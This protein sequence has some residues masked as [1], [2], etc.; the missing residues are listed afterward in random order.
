MN[1]TIKTNVF[2]SS[3]RLPVDI[4]TATYN[5]LP[6]LTRQE[7]KDDCDINFILAKFENQQFEDIVTRNPQQPRFE[8]FIGIPDFDESLNQIINAQNAFEELPAKLR[9]RFDNKPAKLLQ[10]M[11]DPMNREEGIRLGLFEPEMQ[12][13]PEF[14]PTVRILKEDPP[15]AA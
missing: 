15:K 2:Y 14:I 7:F 1:E 8:N 12:P 3:Y 6:S 13:E 4:D 10:F 11:Q 9:D 5:E